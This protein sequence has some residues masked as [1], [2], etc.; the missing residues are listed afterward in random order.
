MTTQ[1]LTRRRGATAAVAGLLALAAIMLTGAPAVADPSAPPQSTNPPSGATATPTPS[2]SVPAPNPAVGAPGSISWAVQPSSATGPDPRSTFTYTNLTPG[3]AIHDYV[4]VTNFSS[5]PVTFSLR[6]ADAYVNAN[7]D[8]DLRPAD[9][10]A[11]DIGSWV[12]FPKDSITLQPNERVNEP[13]TVTVPATATPGDHSGGVI[14]STLVTATNPQGLKVN[15]DRRLAVPLF[16]RVAGPLNPG[17]TIESV[18]TRYHGTYNPVG[19]GKIDVTYTVHNTGNE[20]LNLSQDISVTGFF[21]FTLASTRGKTLVNLLPGAT[22]TATLHL[23]GVFPA[24]LMK[25]H[26]KG[27][28]AEPT[29]LP[30]S[31]VKPRN[32]DFGASMWA[33]P[34]LIILILLVLGGG[35]FGT[36]WLVRGRRGRRELAVSEAMEKARRETIE[37]L[38]KKAAAKVAA[39]TGGTGKGTST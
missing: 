27:V 23:T 17:L 21:G 18:S 30:L 20:R 19:G 5:V 16:L 10:K 25:V 29:G 39:G 22:Y 12:T 33:T 15:V 37:Q 28:P 13:F 4:G 24:G 26:I 9:E 38:R 7:G 6:S 31:L 36:R 35:F 1:R 34:W 14:A 11:K 3:V 8:F 32:V 2:P